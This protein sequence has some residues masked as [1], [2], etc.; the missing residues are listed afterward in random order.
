MA[1]MS[2]SALAAEV[3]ESDLLL[4]GLTI[5]FGHSGMAQDYTRGK[6]LLEQACLD[7]SSA[8]CGSWSWRRPEG[9]EPS[10]VV[11][12]FEPACRDGDPVACLPAA[13]VLLDPAYETPNAALGQELLQAS[14]DL[15]LPEGCAELAMAGLRGAIPMDRLTSME[16]LSSACTDGS[17]TACAALAQEDPSASVELADRACSLDSL[18][19]CAML[20]E[21]DIQSSRTEKGLALHQMACE[22]GYLGSCLALGRRYSKGDG[23]AADPKQA[24][25]IF[26]RSCQWGDS[27]GCEEAGAMLLAGTSVPADPTAAWGLIQEGCTLGDLAQCRRVVAYGPPFALSEGAFEEVAETLTRSCLQADD[28]ACGSLGLA[29]VLGAG[30]PQDIAWGLDILERSCVAGDAYSCQDL[31]KIHAFGAGVDADK[32]TSRRYYQQ[33][34]QAG[35]DESCQALPK[36]MR[37][38]VAVDPSRG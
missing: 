9:P 32:G 2:A 24:L 4:E 29:N 7:G 11:A 13:W 38:D 18:W 28:Q 31:G 20:A 10:A 5:S 15:G 30:V 14:C 34:C 12:H 17:G 3:I 37:P 25:R 21:A 22:D 27:Q 19:G 33:A 1:M 6:E 8:A 26:E 35:L 16:L 36:R 23:V